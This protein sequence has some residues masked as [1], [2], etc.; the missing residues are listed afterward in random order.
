MARKINLKELFNN[1]DLT[2]NLTIGG[3]D[4]TSDGPSALFNGLKTDLSD[5]HL[6]INNSGTPPYETFTLTFN[7]PIIADKI[8]IKSSTRIVVNY[9]IE[10]NGDSNT[11]Q[12]RTFN[13]GSIREDIF[14]FNC[15]SLSSILFRINS[16]YTANDA[17][18]YEIELFILEEADPYE[19]NDSVLSTKAW[20]SSRYDGR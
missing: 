15:K 9:D 10:I 2:Y 1:G 6:Q 3:E 8:R 14:D 12:N 5:P 16:T 11:L 20:N 19:F 17:E 18:F 13:F 4:V 7:T